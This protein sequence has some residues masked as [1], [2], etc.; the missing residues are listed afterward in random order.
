M[1]RA[2]IFTSPAEPVR[3]GRQK[4]LFLDDFIIEES[5]GLARTLH[6]PRRLGPVIAPESEAGQYAVQSRNVPR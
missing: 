6:R 2:S 3:I 4:Q 1:S 5:A